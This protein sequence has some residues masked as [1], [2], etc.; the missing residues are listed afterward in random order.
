MEKGYVFEKKEISRLAR[1]ELYR[2]DSVNDCRESQRHSA[3]AILFFL[4]ASLLVEG[5]SYFLP[6]N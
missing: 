4:V 6:V 5:K 2:A 3:N 1:R